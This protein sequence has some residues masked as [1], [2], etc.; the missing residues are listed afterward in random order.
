MKKILTVS[1][2]KFK[3]KPSIS[4]V[5]SASKLRCAISIKHTLDFKDLV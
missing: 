3:C 4:S 5:D 1:L 2:M